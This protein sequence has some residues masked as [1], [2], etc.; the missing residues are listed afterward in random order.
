MLRPFGRTLNP[1]KNAPYL[2]HKPLTQF[3]Q[4]G[5][6]NCNFVKCCVFRGTLPR[7]GAVSGLF[8]IGRIESK[9]LYNFR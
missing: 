8:C 7:N 3:V 1:L 9:V 5:L 4:G 2:E 6:K